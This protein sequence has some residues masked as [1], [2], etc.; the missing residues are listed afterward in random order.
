MSLG[1]S[2][3]QM[4]ESF[5]AQFEAAGEGAF[6]YRRNQKSEPVP[7]TADERARFVH[8]YVR[9]IWF[10]LW[11]MMAALPAFVALL[12]W[13]TVAT[14]SD[15]P[16]VTMYVGIGAIAVVSIGLMYWI[17][18]APARELEGRT[19]VGRERSKDEMQAILFRKLSY[20]QL[21]SVAVMGAILPFTLRSH[22]DVF[23]GW[24]RLWLLFGGAVIALAAD[25]AL[26]K[27]RFES[28]ERDDLIR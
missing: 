5:E 1:S 21:A 24:G 12:I 15:L 26:R 2:V 20:G 17:R 6:L 16:E 27:W 22:P 19:P 14:N 18:G 25:Q 4:R 7:V 23:H 28:E 10:I 9:R 13:R 8:Q 11:G 3:Q